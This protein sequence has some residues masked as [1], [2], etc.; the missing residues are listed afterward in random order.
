MNFIA[1]ANTLRCSICTA[2]VRFVIISS[3]ALLPHISECIS[4]VSNGLIIISADGNYWNIYWMLKKIA[5]KETVLWFFIIM[6]AFIKLMLLKS[7][8]LPNI[9]VRQPVLKGSQRGMMKMEKRSRSSHLMHL[10][11]VVRGSHLGIQGTVGIRS[12]VFQTAT[13]LQMGLQLLSAPPEEKGKITLL[14]M[15]AIHCS[16]DL[17]TFNWITVFPALT[18]ALSCYSL[19]KYEASAR[20]SSAKASN[21]P[22]L[23][24]TK[25]P[26]PWIHP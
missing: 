26:H 21:H 7:C 11:V 17:T 9:F 23:L 8:Y 2:Y 3:G 6:H 16:W 22:R 25:R 12:V 19:H 18:L 20:Q 15:G 14:R 5:D 13:L 1:N 4:N 10:Q 24:P